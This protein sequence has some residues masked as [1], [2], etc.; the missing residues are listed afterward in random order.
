MNEMQATRPTESGAPWLPLGALGEWAR[1]ATALRLRNRGWYPYLFLVCFIAPVVAWFRFATG[2]PQE[3]FISTIGGICG[4]FYFLYRQHLDE[5]K[6]FKE[7]FV[8]FN[9]RHDE[10]KDD[11]N[12]VLYDPSEGVLSSDQREKVFNYFNLCAEE[13]FFYKAGYI[14]H[15]VWKS[16]C[17]GMNLFFSHPRIQG[18]W[19]EE[20]KESYY[21]FQP[22]Q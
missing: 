15:D 19:A 7:L 10:L 11:L 4:F 17:R 5:T 12:A 8:S 21:G 2:Q 6:L 18:L 16:W 20:R 22:P 3:L 13:Y 14:D 1:A 9:G